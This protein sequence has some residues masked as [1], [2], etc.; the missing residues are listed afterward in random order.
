MNIKMQI[1]QN[2]VLHTRV[3]SHEPCRAV[4]RVHGK[5][6]NEGCRLLGFSL[7]RAHSLSAPTVSSADFWH[8]SYLLFR[9][10]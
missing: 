9:V 5:D 6:H 4:L 7:G 8:A 10:S 2:P 1:V 3:Q